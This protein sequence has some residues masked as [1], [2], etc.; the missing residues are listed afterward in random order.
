MTKKSNVKKLAAYLSLSGMM[1]NCSHIPFGERD[2]ASEGFKPQTAYE[3]WGA[4]NHSA[5]S[6][7]AVALIVE[8]GQTVPGTS[9]G[10]T[11]GAEKEASSSLITRVMGPAPSVLKTRIST[12]SEE[13][14]TKFYKDFIDNYRKNANGY[15][16]YLNEQGVK[17]DLAT[18]VKDA[19]GN[20]KLIDLT[21]M[22]EINL[23]TATLEELTAVFDDFLEQTD[24]RPMSFIK[25]KT[26]M[27]LFKGDLPGLDGNIFATATTWQGHKIPDYNVWVPN[28]GKAQKYLVNAH[29]HNGGK[30][31]WEINFAPLDTYG[32]FEEMVSWFKN[33]LKQNLSN[34]ADFDKAVK[35]FQAPGHQRMV[36]TKHSNLPEEKLAELYRMIQTYIVVNGIQ[37]NTGIEFARFKEVIGDDYLKSLDA[38]YNRGVIRVEGDRWGQGTLG[39]EFRAGTKDLSVARF[40][41][42]VL[43]ARVSANDYDGLS[44]ISDYKLYGQQFQNARNISQRF[45]AKLSDVEKAL[46]ILEKAGIRPSY[47]IQFWNWTGN[48]TPFL[49]KPKKQ[50]LSS[51]TRDYIEKLASLDLNDF[52]LK[53][54]VR[55][56]GI[57]WTSASRL[58]SELENY[59]RPKRA[60]T[61][62][63][64][65]IKFK[66]P[67]GRQF[68][69]NTVD[70][71][72]V[73]LGIEYSGKFPLEV[74]GD[75]SKD[76]LEDG[77]RAWI[78][79]K[80]DLTT[81]EREA[82]I[83]KVADDLY[84]E[85]K[86]NQAPVKVESD[87]HGH[88]LDVAYEI[89]DHKN[90]KWIVEWDGIGR[91]YTPEGTIIEDSPRGGS[92]ELVTP[93]FTPELNEINAVYKA[94]EKNNIL[95]HLKSG[96][97]HINVDLA[98]FKDN[99]KALARFL[100]IFHEHRGIMSLMFQHVMR[101]HTSEQ[102]SLSDNLVSK[103]K[104]FNGSEEELKALLYNERY[105]NTRFG[106]KT[107]YLQLDLSAYFQD[108]IPDEF[109]TKDFDISNPQ[110]KWR[111]QFRVDPRI[112]KA[113]FRMFN[114]PRD[115]MESALQ[116]KLVRA[117]LSKALNEE[118][119]LPGKVS[120][121]RHGDYLKNQNKALSDLEKM[122]NDLGLDVNEFKPAMY[123]GI[124]ET[125]K[126]MRSPFF[127][128]LEDKLKNNPHQKGWAEAVSARHSENALNSENRTWTPGQA[129]EFNTMTNEHRIE[130][131]RLGQQMRQNVTPAR[132]LP[133]EFVKTRSCD[134]LINSIL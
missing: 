130:A 44:G 43:A 69:S 61:Y 103:L 41:Q 68:V 119:Q 4:L 76:R 133:F 91:S 77:K 25:P 7:E 64:D 27:K 3:A 60:F 86:G 17:V 113:E 33:E 52:N 118:D 15:R 114:A 107:R 131:S 14:Q 110:T 105:F 10:V 82:I 85:L 12:L 58:K 62:N 124:A 50:L 55:N 57:E 117:L 72:K 127:I 90:R 16:T 37:G 23:E 8:E 35:L 45:G 100:T 24:G 102:I 18:D 2:I 95:P 106:R 59:M 79:T 121:M 32:E 47:Q 108:I 129:D 73:D 67:E 93:K 19:E 132:E 101:T 116:I 120:N 66:L 48:K 78:Q 70:V 128:S 115:A 31:G 46:A 109:I 123:E 21:K 11:W 80:V 28:F 65:V 40:Y 122:C 96:G 88:G 126:S 74:R 30:G 6:Y 54:H 111:R 104:N 34:P 36:F 81:E 125:E 39:I 38:R 5:T 56:I 26:R 42:T 53:D 75:F 71:N 1:Y 13:N 99:P 51:L 112:R 94:F 83:K 20:A 98:A 9:S 49:S 89:R 92:I 84:K 97:G 63:N 134:E 87:G 29:G 22:K